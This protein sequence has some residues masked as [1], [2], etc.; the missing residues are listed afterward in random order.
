M[1]DIFEQYAP[2]W[3]NAVKAYALDVWQNNDSDD[4][5]ETYNRKALLFS[6]AYRRALERHYA[7]K[8]MRIYRGTLDGKV[9]DWLASQ[10]AL[11]DTLPI[12]I[13]TRQ[14]ELLT[15]EINRLKNDESATAQKLLNKIYDAKENENVYKVFSFAGSY[16]DKA[17]QIGDENAYDLGTKINE[18]IIGQF[19]DRYFWRT[20]RDRRVRDTHRQL[21][22]TCFLFSDPPTEVMRNGTRHTGNPGSAWGC[23]CWAD[24]ADKKTKPKRG[25]K[26]YER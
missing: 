26:A 15:R 1:I 25:F 6:R 4:A 20:Q 14:G 17:E 13:E 9:N 2:R 22:D 18:E 24:V 12:M 11:R 3:S 16:K 21:A 19:S 5:R 7:E 8:G 10:Y 23:R